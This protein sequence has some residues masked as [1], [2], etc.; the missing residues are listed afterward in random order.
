[1]IEI[2]DIK[3][4]DHAIIITTD[5][6]I[7]DRN[8]TTIKIGYAIFD[9]TEIQFI[10]IDK[11]T[12]LSH[13]RKSTRY[14]SSQQNY[15]SSTPEHQRQ[16]N[17]VQAT[18]ETQSDPPGIDNKETTEL[19]LNHIN[20]ESTDSDTENTI[21]INMIHVENDY[22]PIIYEQPIY[23]HIY[24]NHDQ[25]VLN[26]FTRPIN[27]NKTK[28]KIVEEIT[29][30]KPTEFSSTNNIYPNIPKEPQLP[31]EKIWTIPLLLES[32]KCKQLQTPDLEIDFLIDSERNQ[33]SSF[34]PLGMK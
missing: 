16:I 1:M 2:L 9:K 24:Q 20:C 19:Q 8:I 31:K 15:R 14:Q 23:S 12:T 30:E 5:Q 4:I 34:F 11:E 13:H 29:E 3:T 26:Y 32:P 28:E 18:Q 22:E 17:Q 25:F 33:I 7:T 6:T 27:R 21:L 10:T